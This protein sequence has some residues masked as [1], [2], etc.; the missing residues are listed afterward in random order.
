M[1]NLNM[2]NYH[3]HIN[4][5]TSV[6]QSLSPRSL[7]STTYLNYY[8]FIFGGFDVF[9]RT[10]GFYKFSIIKKFGIKLSLM[11]FLILQEKY[12]S[13]L[14]TKIHYNIWNVLM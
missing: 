2:S 12:K 1:D 14:L 4:P 9:S 10:N 11:E 6:S 5:I 13:L 7:I 8:I 3:V